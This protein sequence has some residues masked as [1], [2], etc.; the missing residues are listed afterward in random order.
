MGNH[1]LVVHLDQGRDLTKAHG[2]VG[3]HNVVQP[4]IVNWGTFSRGLRDRFPI[5][6]SGE[7]RLALPLADV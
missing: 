7:R 3:H 4:R 5:R 2:A 1:S 6:N